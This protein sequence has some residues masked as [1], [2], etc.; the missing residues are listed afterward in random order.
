MMLTEL[1]SDHLP[2][3]GN[4]FDDGGSQRVGAS[5]RSAMAAG[6]ISALGE[7]TGGIAHD[8]RNVLCIIASGLRVAE[9]DAADLAKLKS[10]LAATRDGIERGLQMTS[11]LLAFATH[12]ELSSGPETVNTL[13][14]KLSDFLRFGAGPGVRVVIDLA[15]DLPPCLVDPPQFNSAI[16]NLVV[17][18]RDA[19]PHGGVV[20]VRTS[21]IVL[22]PQPDGRN[23]YVRVR[24][25]DE[26]A[27]MPPE[28]LKRI[29]D[30]Y[31]TTKGDSGSGLGLPQVHA[32]MEQVGGHI[33]V[34][35]AVGAGTSFDLFF[36]VPE[37]HAENAEISGQLERWADEGGAVV[38]ISRESVEP[39]KEEK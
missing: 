13:L 25:H 32:L 39:G 3:R 5:V 21:S 17:N 37:K 16:L 14:E 36:P 23:E 29:F 10:A 7:M 27:G 38:R 11:R 26:G 22:A 28:V 15:D 2:V 18:A 35:S 30:P 4:D 20:H 12:Q 24:V 6:K 34:D 31:F 1:V 33:H 19:M 8:F 9:R